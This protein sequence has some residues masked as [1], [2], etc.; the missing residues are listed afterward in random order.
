[1]IEVTAYQSSSGMIMTTR[2]TRDILT[3]HSGAAC[4]EQMEDGSDERQ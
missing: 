3:F 2:R 1:M 4:R